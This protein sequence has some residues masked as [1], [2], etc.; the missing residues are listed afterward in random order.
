MIIINAY[1]HMTVITTFAVRVINVISRG[2]INAI[3]MT[4]IVQVIPPNWAYIFKDNIAQMATH[5][6]IIIIKT[7]KC[8]YYTCR[9]WIHIMY[10]DIHK[11]HII[12]MPI[13]LENV[14]HVYHLCNICIIMCGVFGELCIVIYT[15]IIIYA[16]L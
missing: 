14:L 4:I 5:L 12:N 15:Y 6:N 8:V 9:F 7:Y 1:F 3:L 2:P 16:C 11:V 10:I 13:S